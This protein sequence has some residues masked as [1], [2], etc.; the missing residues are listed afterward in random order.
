VE[1]ADEEWKEK[2]LDEIADYLNGL[3]C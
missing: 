1:E 2:P 3:A